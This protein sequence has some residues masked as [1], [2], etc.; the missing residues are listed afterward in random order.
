[1]QQAFFLFSVWSICS[2]LCDDYV[3]ENRLAISRANGVK[4]VVACLSSADEETRRS[5]VGCLINLSLSA[6]QKLEV[7]QAG[8]VKSLVQCLSSTDVET[9]RYTARALS[10]LCTVGVYCMH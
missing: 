5:A 9:V 6:P 1:M 2:S 4:D 8:G 3:E 7:K 10:N